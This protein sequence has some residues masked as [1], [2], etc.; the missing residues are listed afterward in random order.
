[1]KRITFV[2]WL[3]LAAGLYDGLLGAAFL[4]AGPAL[5][6]RFGVTPPN[7][8]GYVQFPAALLV[9][10]AVMF[11]AVAVRPEANRNLML[12]G[13]GLKLSYCGVVFYHWSAGPLPAMWKPFAVCDALF[14]LLFLWSWLATRRS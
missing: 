11:F 5:F 6:D 7:H 12:A 4:L 1:M 14:A 2:R 8:W 9:V 10:F 13:V 3:W